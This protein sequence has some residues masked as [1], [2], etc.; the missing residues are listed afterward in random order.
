LISKK[1]ILPLAL[2]AVIGAGAY[3]VSQASAASSQK[4]TLAQ[5][6]ASAFGLDPSKVE[7]VISQYRQGQMTNKEAN[8]QTNLNKAVTDGKLTSAQESAIMTEHNTLAAQLKSAMA[9]TGS[10]RIAAI[11]QVKQDA[12]T[13][14]TSNNV[15][16]RWLLGGRHL[17][18]GMDQTD[19]SSGSSSN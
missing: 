7:T 2:V 3:G 1:V 5:S 13:W 17:R 11:K 18:G 19:Q 14:A 10:A 8:Y 9:Q 4:T 16:A 6:I 12:K 15:P